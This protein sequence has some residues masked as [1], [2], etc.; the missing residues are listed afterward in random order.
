MTLKMTIGIASAAMVSLVAFSA[1]ADAPCASFSVPRD[2]VRVNYN[3]FAVAVD[4]TNFAVRT[5]RRDND[6]AEVRF[7]L[8]DTTPRGDQPVIGTDG[9]AEYTIEARDEAGRTVFDWRSGS[10]TPLNGLNVMFRD[11]R[12]VASSNLTLVIPALQPSAATRHTQPLDVVFECYDSGGSL[13]GNGVQTSQ[14]LLLDLTVTRIFGAYTGTIGQRNG[15]IDF[16]PIDV[17]SGAPLTSQAAITALSS[18]RY[19][20]SIRSDRNFQI[21]QTQDGPGLPYSARL[22]GIAINQYDRFICPRS[23]PTGRNHQIALELDTRNAANLPAGDYSDTLTVTFLA[24]DGAD[25]ATRGG[26]VAG[27]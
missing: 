6:V 27:D 5:Q 8:K 3:P 16:G 26:C 4:R 12:N 2:D 20:L 22:D 19:G 10:L 21:R 15:T 25:V 23:G 1:H 14:D 24:R 9:P 18:V 13:V 11:N 17:R 7:L